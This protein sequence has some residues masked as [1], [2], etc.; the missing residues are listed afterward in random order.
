VVR[1]VVT[2]DLRAVSII[3]HAWGTDLETVL[4]VPATFYELRLTLGFA[5]RDFLKSLVSGRRG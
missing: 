1:V 2:R 5:W 3:A 4:A